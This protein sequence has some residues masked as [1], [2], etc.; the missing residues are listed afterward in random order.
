MSIAL[1]FLQAVAYSLLMEPVYLAQKV[2]G[3]RWTWAEMV[4]CGLT[5]AV[6]LVSLV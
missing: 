2:A 6:F 3:T 1:K 5:H 4:M